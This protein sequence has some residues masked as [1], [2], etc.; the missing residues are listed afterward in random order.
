MYF[1]LLIVTRGRSS[2]FLVVDACEIWSEEGSSRCSVTDC[3]RSRICNYTVKEVSGSL[4]VEELAISIKSDGMR[5]W[6]RIKADC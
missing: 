3:S 6:L 5:S 4:K 1:L 2:I